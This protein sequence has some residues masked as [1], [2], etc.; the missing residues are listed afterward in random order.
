MNNEEYREFF[1]RNAQVN[2]GTKA[3]Q[4][5]G[6]PVKYIVKSKSVFNR[7][8]K[9]HY[10]TE[11]VFT[12]LFKSITFKLNKEDTANYNGTDNQGLVKLANDE[13]TQTRGVRDVTDFAKVVQPYQLPI[14]TTQEYIESVIAEDTLNVNLTNT[15][16]Y[17]GV[18]FKIYSIQ[19][20]AGSSLYKEYWAF[21]NTLNTTIN[22]LDESVTILLNNLITDKKIFTNETFNTVINI[23]TVINGFESGGFTMLQKDAMCKFDG[24]LYYNGLYDYN[25]TFKIKFNGDVYASKQFISKSF[26]TSID[27]NEF[28][29][30][31]CIILGTDVNATPNS[32]TLMLE[33][34]STDT[35]T[36]ITF[37]DN[38]QLSL[39]YL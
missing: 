25:I 2:V 4:E 36:G 33:I 31:H 32:N 21:S 37:V 26:E 1:L 23:D 7:F 39:Y 9:D 22:S 11:N 10:P 35:S 20:Q 8:L 17:Q 24:V 6:F 29:S 19:T 38:C 28:L 5:T 16:T 14:I 27:L 18:I 15:L 12:K 3:D 30:I 34:T 13:D